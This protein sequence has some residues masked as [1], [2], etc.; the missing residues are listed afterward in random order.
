MSFKVSSLRGAVTTAFLLAVTD[1]AAAQQTPP[2]TAAATERMQSHSAW[3]VARTVSGHVGRILAGPAAVG[4]EEPV[5]AMDYANPGLS[6]GTEGAGP[7]ASATAETPAWSVWVGP[8]VTWSDQNDSVAGNEGHTLTTHVGLDRRVG[9]RGV[10]GVLAGF[11]LS[12]FDTAMLGGSLESEGGGVGVYA[13]YGLSDTIVLDALALYTWIDNDFSDRLRSADYDSER[14][15]LSANVTVYL[16]EGRLSIRP[17]LGVSYSQDD[18]EAYR[19]TLGIRSPE[20][21][22]ETLGATVGAQV[23]YTFFLD[24]GRSIEPYLGAT[25]VLEDSSTDPSSAGSD[26]LGAFDLRLAAG[27]NAQLGERVSLSLSA[28]VSGLGR[29]DYHAVT[30]GGQLSVQF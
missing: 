28:D 12:D 30:L 8:N 1:I 14:L 9:T 19:D 7:V 15:Q 11:E 22:V 21:E 29:G 13:G 6:T 25:A 2:V 24:E 27:A 3:H 16:T 23:G 17:K 18:Q 26:E 10:V 5:A 4:R 20:T